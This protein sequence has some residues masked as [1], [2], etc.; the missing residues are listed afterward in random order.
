MIT[1]EFRAVLQNSTFTYGN[2]FSYNDPTESTLFFPNAKD[3]KAELPFIMGSGKH[4][5]VLVYADANQQFRNRVLNTAK[6]KE[7]MDGAHMPM[8]LKIGERYYLVGKGF[9]A[10]YPNLEP[11]ELLFVA[12]SQG[13]ITSLREVKYYVARSLKLPEHKKVEPII[14]DFMKI[15]QGDLILTND[16]KAYICPKIPIPRL[17]TVAERLRFIDDLLVMGIEAYKKSPG[18]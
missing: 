4:G 8:K 2:D 17:A 10:T 3:P 12:T 18:V 11:M 7:I 5:E 1:M 9:L 15:H 13:K 16:I 14:R 6:I